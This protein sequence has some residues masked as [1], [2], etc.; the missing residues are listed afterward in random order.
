MKL[1][2]VFM[3]AAIPICCYADGSS[4]C[5]MMD[6]II[7]STLDPS[8][9]VDDYHATIKEAISL[10]YNK[11]AVTKFKE[12]FLAQNEET[13]KNMHVMMEAIYASK[14]CQEEA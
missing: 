11:E 4:G 2:V 12:C 9:S 3:L 14:D 7:D 8:V 1:V 10:P 6:T 5:S 13:V